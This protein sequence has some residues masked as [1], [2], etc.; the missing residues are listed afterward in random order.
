MKTLRICR[1]PSSP[2]SS[3]QVEAEDMALKLRRQQ[4]TAVYWAHL[5]G[6]DKSHP[7]LRLLEQCWDD[8]KGECHRLLFT[9][10]N[11]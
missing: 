7:T 10:Q 8:G 2:V 6:P 11:V 1:G 4:L 5:M 3:L 9:H